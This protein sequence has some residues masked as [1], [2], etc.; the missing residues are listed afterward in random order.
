MAS[1]VQANQKKMIPLSVAALGVVYGDIGT[2]PLYALRESL[3]GLAVTPQNV[4]GVLSL[5]FWSLIIIVSVK[6]LIY[7]LRADN[8]GEGGILALLALLRRTNGQLYTILFFAGIFGAGLLV[9][10]A[11]LTPAIS[12]VSAIEGLEVISPAFS[13]IVLPLTTLIL[14]FLFFF[15]YQGTA[16]IGH[17]FGPIILTWFMI[18]GLLG[19]VHII[20]N[21]SVIAAVNPYYA[22]EFF[23]NNGFTA[24]ILLGGVFLAVT[25][26]EALY[27]DL[28]HFGKTP[29]RI[30]WFAV[31]LP[32][33]VLNYFGQGAY[34]LEDPQAI[35]N[36][37]YS[38]APPWFSYPLLVVATIATIIASQAVIS[39]TFSLAKQA[40]LLELYPRVTI[41][42][43]S[44]EEKGQI[45]VPQMNYIMA[46]G[47][48]LL[49]IIF[50]NSSALTHAY[51][52]AVNLEML[53]VVPMV[54]RVAYVYWE[55][56]IVKVIA[57]FSIFLFIDLA[58][59]GANTH[60]IFTGGWIPLL[61]AV[62]CSFVM[63]TWHRGMEYLRS[64]YYKEKA[65]L[66]EIIHDLKTQGM[67]QSPNTA[68]IFITDFYDKSGGSLLHYIKLNRILPEY[69][70]IVSVVVENY[71]YI[72]GRA[73][74]EV[75]KL[76]KNIC[77]IILHY[78]FM[79][80][81]D[82]PDT[83]A[84]AVQLKLI[85]FKLPLEQASYLIEIPSVVATRR[86]ATLTFFWQE[87]L[88]EFLMRNSSLD[89]EFFKL[90]YNRTIAIGT[91]CEI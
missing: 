50:K 70:L 13:Y 79:D 51:G 56:N 71:P 83:L 54:M 2:S 39:A 30:G 73:R 66:K 32:G 42:Q 10:D 52:I 80:T 8:D 29:I 69:V 63:L 36:P 74:Y 43:T 16:R 21:P 82:L 18:I 84:T 78:G 76:E 81:I 91:Y 31:A 55:W 57:I 5:I 24:Y 33:L 68:A 28:G 49:V 85:P 6:Y 72:S 1:I 61:F 25:G 62:I 88:F 59:L 19:L 45:Y 44:E 65:D 14:I 34:L 60:K 48:I 27:A 37:F 15:Q 58:F 41:V 87:K 4:L 9:G 40:V 3:R 11:M 12:V 53:V 46:I 17:Y 86:T 47:T 22:Y 75:K 23:Y 35:V 89:I 38:I 77:R 64:S 90:P 67:T 7:I 26:G 20:Q